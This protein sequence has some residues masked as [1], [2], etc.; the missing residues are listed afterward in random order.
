LAVRYSDRVLDA[1]FGKEEDKK[2]REPRLRLTPFLRPASE[3]GFD[4]KGE[5]KQWYFGINFE[6]IG[7]RTARHVN[8]DMTID[9]T[10]HIR[11]I[12]NE[13]IA[14]PRLYRRRNLAI[15]YVE[16]RF[17]TAS[18]EIILPAGPWRRKEEKRFPFGGFVPPLSSFSLRL[19]GENLRDEDIF[20]TDWDLS[21]EE[22][23][24]VRFETDDEFLD[25]KTRGGH[26]KL[27]KERENSVIR[28][29]LSSEEP[30]PR[31]YQNLTNEMGSKG[32]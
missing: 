26:T 18:R 6:N 12:E 11:I 8:G 5:P 9:G 10:H 29:D 25:R 14:T 7:E 4:E 32:E 1:V 13:D 21:F 3:F 22:D 17:D 28:R 30:T 16:F 2:T 27:M 15:P 19:S 23:G 24:R 31:I 20:P